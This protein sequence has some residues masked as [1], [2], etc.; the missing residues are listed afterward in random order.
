MML[1]IDVKNLLEL[2]ASGE[3][4]LQE[5]ESLS[6]PAFPSCWHLLAFGFQS[7]ACVVPA[8]LPRALL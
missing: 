1:T 5:T 8:L 7:R 4:L 2:L 3:L 6:L